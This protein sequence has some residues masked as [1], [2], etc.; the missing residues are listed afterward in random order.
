METI[1]RL[2]LLEPG[3][4]GKTTFFFSFFLMMGAGL[5]VGKGY[6]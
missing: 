5:A 1:A 4:G 3:E 6:A 2:F